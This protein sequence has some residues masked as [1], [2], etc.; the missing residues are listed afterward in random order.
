[1]DN[2]HC[3]INHVETKEKEI[4]ERLC[5]CKEQI[6]GVQAYE[7]GQQHIKG[8]KEKLAALTKQYEKKIQDKKLAMRATQQD[9]RT[10]EAKLTKVKE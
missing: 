4:E 10:A 2:L 8:A 1:M 7:A 5:I 6:E 3:F 9:A